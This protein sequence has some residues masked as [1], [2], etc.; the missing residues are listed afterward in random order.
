M[1]L[2]SS[3]HKYCESPR[4]G[5]STPHA[6]RNTRAAARG[7]ELC[8]VV[9]L[10]FYPMQLLMW[11]VGATLKANCTTS[12]IVWRT[13]LTYFCRDILHCCFVHKAGFQGSL[14]HIFVSVWYRNIF[15]N[16]CLLRNCGLTAISIHSVSA[17]AKLVGVQQHK[18]GAP[19]ISLSVLA[20]P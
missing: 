8:V 12:K 17:A 1:W 13:A 10:C 9:S 16:S 20:S 11:H 15:L 5:S 6:G 14:G 18:S 2:P 7:E 19:N 4:D 3:V